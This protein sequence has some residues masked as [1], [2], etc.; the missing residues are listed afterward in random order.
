MV[1][2]HK[3]RKNART[4]CVVLN[5]FFFVKS[6]DEEQKDS[7]FCQ[8]VMLYGELIRLDVFSHNAYLCTL[9]SRGDLESTSSTHSASE[10]TLSSQDGAGRVD[11]RNQELLH[12]T[13]I[14][15]VTILDFSLN[16]FSGKKE[17]GQKKASLGIFYHEELRN[18]QAIYVH[19]I[20]YESKHFRMS[21]FFQMKNYELDP[22]FFTV[23]APTQ[24]K[25][26][27]T[28]M[29]KFF[30]RYAIHLEKN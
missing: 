23:V 11:C 22:N 26:S 6:G 24:N 9:I 28:T 1:E 15:E 3:T 8:L 18:L 21:P 12:E 29:P 30:T 4:S 17:P 19:S 14:I 5:S 2:S 13:T 16:N 27:S 7:R 20:F 25:T 10:N